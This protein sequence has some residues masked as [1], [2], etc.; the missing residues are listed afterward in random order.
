MHRKS[1][2]Q[3]PDVFEGPMHLRKKNIYTKKKDLL[4]KRSPKAVILTRKRNR[5]LGY[6]KNFGMLIF[7]RTIGLFFGIKILQKCINYTKVYV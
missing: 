3:P 7:K 5:A 4:L 1:F 6:R 2:H